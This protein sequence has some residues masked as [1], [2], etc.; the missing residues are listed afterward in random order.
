MVFQACETC[1]LRRSNAEKKWSIEKL[2]KIAIAHTVDAEQK[3]VFESRSHNVI[4][5][6]RMT[7][8]QGP[9][10]I[11]E[12]I[13]TSTV[14]SRTEDWRS[15]HVIR[16]ELYDACDE[17]FLVCLYRL[18]KCCR[19]KK[20]WNYFI[21]FES[22]EF[23]AI[24]LRKD[25]KFSETSATLRR[26]YCWILLYLPGVTESR[27]LGAVCAHNRYCSLGP[28]A[29]LKYGCSIFFG[30]FREFLTYLVF[31]YY[32]NIRTATTRMW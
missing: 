18:F 26:Y 27:T 9:Q 3:V 29:S 15:A 12:R 2:N 16:I 13:E 10:E 30:I 28:D 23:L 7:W 21:R 17:E 19:E 32:Y 24:L 31:I 4:I 22:W 11:F 6:T 20:N 14:Q 25:F 8:A 1:H 5:E